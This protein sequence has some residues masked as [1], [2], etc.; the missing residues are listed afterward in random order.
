MYKCFN[1]STSSPK[2]GIFWFFNFSLIIATLVG[3]KWYLV[4][5]LIYISLITYFVEHL[6]LLFAIC[7]YTFLES[8]QFI[9]PF[10]YW[11]IFFFTIK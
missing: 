8:I 3:A 4:V 11:V 9:C 10:L 7:I 6:L 2:I 1:F 5:V